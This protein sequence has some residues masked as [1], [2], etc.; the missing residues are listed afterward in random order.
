MKRVYDFTM[1]LYNSQ[2][3]NFTY[4][5]FGHHILSFIYCSTNTYVEHFFGNKRAPT[6]NNKKEL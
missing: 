2:V 1:D 5:L 4:K 3:H 6:L